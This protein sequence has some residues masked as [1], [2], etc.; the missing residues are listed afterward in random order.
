MKYSLK[1]LIVH[2]HLLLQMFIMNNNQRKK[3]I[4]LFL[5]KIY[6]IGLKCYMRE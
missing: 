5:I 4:N 6:F 3:N 1:I 2:H